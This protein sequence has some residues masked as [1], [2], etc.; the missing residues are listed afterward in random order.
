MILYTFILFLIA[1]LIGSV[2]TGVIFSRLFGQGDL[3]RRGSR[4]IGATNVSRV[5]G[6]KWGILTLLGD[7][8]K[9]MV[10]VWIGQWGLSGF[11]GFSAYPL[12]LIALGA[13]IGH[14]FPVYLGFKGG[15]GVATALGIF[16]VFSPLVVLLVI[17][18][19]VF[20][21]Y[22]GKYVSLGSMVSAVSFPVLLLWLEYPGATVA[23]S[24]CIALGVVL[25]HH[26][27]IKRI[28]KGE[29]KSWKK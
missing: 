6:K 23:L 10:A 22:L 5:M 24:L 17:P 7:G 18:I 12:A 3:Q 26:E 27:N 8:L 28:I 20:T 13:F 15:K 25:K 29:E 11:A 1:Y 16:L 21:T 14:C 4:N 2:P 19:F 9:G